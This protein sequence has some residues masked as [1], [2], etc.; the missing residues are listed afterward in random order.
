[1]PAAWTGATRRWCA[2]PASRCW[3]APPPAWRPSRTCSPGA[4]T[5]RPAPTGRRPARGP[6]SPRAGARLAAGGRLSELDGL[7]LL[8]DYGIAVSAAVAVGSLDEAV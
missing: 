6:G 3:R 4:S 1:W 7:A 2:P 5:W 8:A